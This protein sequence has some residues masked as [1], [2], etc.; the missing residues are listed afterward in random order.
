MRQLRFHMPFDEFDLHIADRQRGLE[1]DT[2]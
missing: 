1:H 2:G